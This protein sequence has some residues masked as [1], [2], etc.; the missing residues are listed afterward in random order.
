[1]AIL[2]FLFC[3]LIPQVMAD[4]VPVRFQDGTG[5][6]FLTVRSADGR[7]IA[8]G[9]Q[10]QIARGD[11]VT[12]RLVFRF[13]DGSLDDET[14][15]YTQ[16]GVFRLISDHHVQKGPFFPQ[17]S[18]V[19]VDARTGQVTAKTV[20][21]DGKE[22]VHSEHMDLPADLANGMVA[23]LVKNLRADGGETKVSMVVASPKPRVIKLA[24]APIGDEPFRIA[25]AT[26][27]ATHFNLKIELGGIAGVV[28]PLVG[29]QPPDHGIWIY[30]DTAP[31]FVKEEGVLS[32]DSPPVTITMT[33]AQWPKT[34]RVQAAK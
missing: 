3:G 29:K 32:M 9:D 24:I 12:V 19:T 5:H 28:A 30:G 6:G 25:G 10:I 7:L 20:G 22:E 26:R 4:P 17:Q 15:V 16:R 23:E 8:V 31:T 27:K 2:A 21:K 34:Q 13:R 33:S 18:D 14:T 11:R 1:L